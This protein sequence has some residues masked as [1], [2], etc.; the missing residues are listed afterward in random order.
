MQ[1]NPISPFDQTDTPAGVCTVDGWGVKIRVHQGHLTI[2]DGVG[3]SRRT[4]RYHKATSGLRRLVIIG[5]SGYITFEAS[6]WLADAKIQVLHL[7]SEGRILSVSAQSPDLPGLRRAQGKA[8]TTPT[9]IEII[10]YLLTLK[11]AGQQQIAARL[12]DPEPEIDTALTAIEQASDLDSLRIAESQAAV[13]YW[14]A[15]RSAEVRFV[16]VDQATVP[17][18]WLTFGQR[19]STQSASGRRAINPINAILNYLYTLLEA[20]ARIATIAVG[21]DPGLG[22]MH[23][24]KKARDSFALDLMEAGRPAVDAYV[25]DLLEGHVFQAADFTETRAGT[26]R[27]APR[28]AHH[29]THTSTLWHDHLARPAETIARMLAKT[30]RRGVRDLITPLTQTNRRRAKSSTWTAPPHRPTVD[31][32]CERC[33]TPITGEAKLCGPCWS[34]FQEDLEWSTAGRSRLAAMR[35]DGEDPAHGGE[36]GRKRAAKISSENRKSAEWERESSQK[37]DPTV[38]LD[39]ILPGLQHIGLHQMSDATGLSVDYCS[40]IRRGLKTPH[41]RH[42]AALAS[43]TT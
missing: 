26:C 15:W 29:L 23:L 24:D 18:H 22:I 12:G 17:A 6:R 27:I 11:V 9:G 33:G 36:A 32:I 7:D 41:P 25:L 42:W 35:A 3:R 5:H 20:E 21:L 1:A 43:L 4:R 34:R 30:T 8:I 28:L 13:A 37:P 39:M 16:R 14:R 10:R 38:F 31:R 40:K 19:R 2:E